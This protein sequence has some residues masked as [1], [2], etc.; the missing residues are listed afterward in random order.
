MSIDV[1]LKDFSR[2]SL[3]EAI[4]QI[5]L[6]VSRSGSQ[7][8][9]DALTPDYLSTEERKRVSE[10]VAEIITNIESAADFRL[11]EL[12]P[13]QR[14]KVLAQLYSQ[15]SAHLVPQGKSATE[16]GRRL[17]RELHAAE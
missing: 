15:L 17:L 11:D 7:I 10:V 3:I 14:A 6:A 4:Y 13:E 8:D 12:P 2:S 5:S 1:Q 9:S 16:R